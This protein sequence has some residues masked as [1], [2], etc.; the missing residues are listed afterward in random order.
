MWVGGCG[1]VMCVD[2]GVSQSESHS[3]SLTIMYIPSERYS[4]ALFEAVD[5][6]TDGIEITTP[7]SDGKIVVGVSLT[8]ESEVPKLHRCHFPP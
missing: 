5:H 4:Y 8:R 7:E 2:M 1:W 3:Y 6:C